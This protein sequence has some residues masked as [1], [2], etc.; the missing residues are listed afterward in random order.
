[1]NLYLTPYFDKYNDVNMNFKKKAYN[2]MVESFIHSSE[3]TFAIFCGV[4]YQQ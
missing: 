4:A 1:M 3:R 2:V